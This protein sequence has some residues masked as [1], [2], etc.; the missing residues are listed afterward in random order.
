MYIKGKRIASFFVLMLLIVSSLGY[1]QLVPRAFVKFPEL[2]QRLGLFNR[3][4]IV[5]K[6]SDTKQD[7]D[8]SQKAINKRSSIYNAIIITKNKIVLQLDNIAFRYVY[9]ELNGLLQKLMGKLSDN[10]V[11]KLNNGHLSSIDLKPSKSILQD[12]TN[13]ILLNGKLKDNNIPVIFIQAPGKNSKFDNQLPISIKDYSNE[14]CDEF[15]K[16]IRDAEVDCIDLRQIM[17]DEGINQYD[18]FFK[19]DHHWRPE[20]G[21]WAAGKLSEHLNRNYGF[22]ISNLL[23]NPE[24]YNIEIFRNSMLGTWGRRVGISFAGLDDISII[25]PKFSTKFFLKNQSGELIDIGDFKDAFIDLDLIH[26]DNLYIYSGYDAYKVTSFTIST[27]Q[28]RS[29]NNKRIL[30]ICDSFGGVF[31]PFMALSCSTLDKCYTGDYKFQDLY[32]YIEQSSPDLVMFLYT[33][34]SDGGNKFIFK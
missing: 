25:T 14:N 2:F 28:D 16:I 27:I 3:S 12:A 18:M 17:Y 33:A 24:N 8:V 11:Y 5:S 23:Y 26:P 20:A 34:I 21:L 10:G 19:T 7:S 30:L 1:L 22:S 13:L 31:A 6:V 4:A 29:E 9:I 32:D 15:L